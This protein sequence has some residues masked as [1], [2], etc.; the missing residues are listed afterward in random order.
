MWNEKGG[1]IDAKKPTYDEAVSRVPL[2]SKKET[3]SD[4]RRVPFPEA[5]IQL[6]T[7]CYKISI[8]RNVWKFWKSWNHRKKRQCK[9]ILK[10][11]QKSI[12][13]NIL[14]VYIELTLLAIISRIFNKFQ[15]WLTFLLLNILWM[16]FVIKS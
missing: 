11:S 4:S 16:H 5:E 3:E 10:L 15:N 12:N 6:Y 14:N 13:V 1:E 2:N 9:Q 8:I 7:V